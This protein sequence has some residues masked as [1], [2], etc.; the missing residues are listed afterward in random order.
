G[1]VLDSTSSFVPG[2]RVTVVNARTEARAVGLASIEGRFAFP[3]LPPGLYTLSVEAAGFRKAVVSGLVLNVGD[4]ISETVT[5]EVGAVTESIEVKAGA[6]RVQINDAQIARATTLREID[7]L[8]QM[9]RTPITLAIFNPGV[10]IDPADWYSLSRVNGT[11]TG[12]NNTRLDGIDMNDSVTPRLL[13]SIAANSPDSVEEFRMVTSGGQAEYGRSAGGQIEMITR[14]GGNALHGS[15][16][17]YHRN[18]VLNA[19]TFFGNST[20]LDRLVFIRNVFGGS[21]GGPIR[22]E[23]TFFFGDYQGNRTAQEKERHRLVMTPEA[24]AGLFRW[25]LPDST[26][27]GKSD[28]VRNDPKGRGID[29]KVRET[30]ELLPAPNNNSL[31]DGLNNAGFRFNNPAGQYGDQFNLKADHNLWSGH[32][33]FFRYTWGRSSMIDTPNEKDAR[34]PGQPSGTQ[35]GDKWAY[36]IGSDWALTTRLVNELRT[37][38]YWYAWD[39]LSPARLPGAMFLANSWTDPLNPAFGSSRSPTVRPPDLAR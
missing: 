9:E 16:F 10:Q 15:L 12:S 11:R 23:K 17:E 38:Y 14:S 27:I 19:N 8:P 7:V 28:I 35:G 25:K 30:L 22:R 37:G 26:E 13:L 31:G 5:L 29:P 6:E 1:V 4:T 18:T 34:F 33:V 20:G 39:S 36:A 21:L 3:S 32:R 24:K 2:A